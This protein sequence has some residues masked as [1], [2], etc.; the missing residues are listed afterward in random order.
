M[1]ASTWTAATL[2]WILTAGA[3]CLGFAQSTQ[4]IA[5]DEPAARDKVGKEFHALRLGATAAPIRIDGRMDDEV[6]MRAE[7]ISE[8]T[9]EEPDNMMPATEATTVRVAYD[10]RYLY[11]AVQ[12]MMRDAS[13][14]RAGL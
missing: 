14:L 8:F 5:G 3:A 9:Q 7:A 1:R 13:E 12:M 2:V 10:D 11:V 4:T 6:W